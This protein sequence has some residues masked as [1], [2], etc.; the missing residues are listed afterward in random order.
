[1]SDRFTD[2]ARSV[3]RHARHEADRFRHEYIDTEHILL[4]LIHE[5]RGGA[6]N[7]LRDL[8]LDLDKIR[9]ETEEMIVQNDLTMGMIGGLIPFTPRAKKV[10][11]L[12]AEE[13]TNLGHRDIGTEHLLIGLIRET[14]GVAA[15]V[16]ANLGVKLHE[17][18]DE[19][20]EKNPM[21]AI[22]CEEFLSLLHAPDEASHE[23][24]NA[25][26]AHAET[27]APCRAAGE[28]EEADARVM[29]R[30]VVLYWPLLPPRTPEEAERRRREVLDV[31]M[32]RAPDATNPTP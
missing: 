19:V 22:T 32:G 1:M 29:L 9:R 8:D 20:A 12:S 21:P 13:A 23:E 18:R 24:I 11:E 3:M 15:Q 26:G 14:D 10:L 31:V 27:C 7:V 17:V 25:G 5:G 30:N 6:V 28:Q 2:R 4:G 16:L